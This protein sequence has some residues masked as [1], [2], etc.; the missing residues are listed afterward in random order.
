MST[1]A[2]ARS[3]Y[4]KRRMPP[5]RGS[6]VPGVSNG[7]SSSTG[8]PL[9]VPTPIAAANGG[10][11]EV[12][13]PIAT[14]S[15]KKLA[16]ASPAA[17]VVEVGQAEQ[18]S[19]LSEEA[20]DSFYEGLRMLLLEVVQGAVRRLAACQHCNT[21]LDVKESLGLG[22]KAGVVT[23]IVLFCPEC[24]EEDSFPIHLRRRQSIPNLSLRQSW[25][26]WVVL[27]LTRSA[28]HWAC[29]QHSVILLLRSI[30]RSWLSCQPRQL[31]TASMLLPPISISIWV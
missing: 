20:S 22:H 26:V 18:A 11:L 15:G 24:G 5:P 19:A 23:R 7:A 31:K 16:L 8:G 21:I 6:C 17:R 3:G 28:G 13:T 4:K 2:T 1:P 14:A 10:P 29:Q 9:E 12:P 27:A 30:R 25:W